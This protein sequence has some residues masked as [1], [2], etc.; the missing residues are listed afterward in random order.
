[1]LKANI[2]TKFLEWFGLNTPGSNIRTLQQTTA[3]PGQASLDQGFPPINAIPTAGG[4]I[5]PDIRDMNGTLAAVFQ[6]LQWVQAG[7]GLVPWDSAFSSGVTPTAG[8]PNGACVLSATTP[9]AYYVSIVDNNTSNPDAGGANW[10]AGSLYGSFTTGDVKLSYKTT[11]DI[12]FVI[13][14]DGSIG[15]ASSN[16]TTRANADTLPLF[17]LMFNNIVDAWAPLKTSGGGSTNRAAFPS[18]PATAFAANTQLVLPAM[19]GR[20][21]AIGG[22]GM[23]LT[24]RALG[25]NLGEE[26][27]LMTTNELVAHLHSAVGGTILSSAGGGAGFSSGGTNTTEAIGL[28]ATAGNPFN[29]MQPSAFLNAFA[30]L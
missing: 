27:H 16:A 18:G 26:S 21:L 25:Q 5:P 4:G 6:W 11:A 22:F 15:N 13:M 28:N 20:A 17:S 29:V 9:G 1:M 24:A 19:L 3:N 2:P 10:V 14:N 8:Y 12:G 7:G 30:K 23:G